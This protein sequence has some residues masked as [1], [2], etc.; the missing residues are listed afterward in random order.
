M[1]KDIAFHLRQESKRTDVSADI[2]RTLSAAYAEISR[3]RRQRDELKHSESVRRQ[4]MLFD[5]QFCVEAGGAGDGSLEQ[6]FYDLARKE[7][8][9]LVIRDSS[10]NKS[11][12]YI[13]NKYKGALK[14][15]ADSET[16]FVGDNDH[17]DAVP[18]RV[19]KHGMTQARWDLLMQHIN[20]KP[21]PEKLAESELAAGW[22]YCSDWDGL[23]INAKDIEFD[24]CQCESMNK[25]RKDTNG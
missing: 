7:A 1:D 10:V 12:Q 21:T 5:I 17:G 20:D 15:L 11:Y 19:I 14:K 2:I 22:H 25:F 13:A 23:L 4:K 8:D 9:D 24:H 6:L 16:V 3:L 18:T